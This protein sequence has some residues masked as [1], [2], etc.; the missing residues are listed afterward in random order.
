M[1]RYIA[2]VKLFFHAYLY[3]FFMLGPM[4][5]IALHLTTGLIARKT[6]L[7]SFFQKLELSL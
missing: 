3:G 2:F 6:N 4:F 7:P 1:F 5:K